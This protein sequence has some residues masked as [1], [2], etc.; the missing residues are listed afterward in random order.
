MSSWRGKLWLKA[1]ALAVAG[2]FAFSEV[3]WAA[4][5]DFILPS[6]VTNRNIPSAQQNQAP[7]KK[8]LLETFNEIYTNFSSVLFPFA[9]AEVIKEAVESDLISIFNRINRGGEEYSNTSDRITKSEEI[10]GLADTATVRQSDRIITKFSQKESGKVI[11]QTVSGKKAQELQPYQIMSA[12]FNEARKIESTV[13]QSTSDSFYYNL[14]DL[15]SRQ[16]VVETLQIPTDCLDRSVYLFRVAGKFNLAP[17]IV[18]IKDKKAN[19]GHALLAI[20]DSGTNKRVIIETT[21]KKADNGNGSGYLSSYL[22]KG[23]EVLTIARS[24]K[25]LTA[26]LNKEGRGISI[27]WGDGWGSAASSQASSGSYSTGSFTAGSD[28]GTGSTISSSGSSSWYS[29]SSFSDSSSFSYSTAV[30]PSLSST[31]DTSSLYGSFGSFISDYSIGSSFSLPSTGVFSFVYSTISSSFDYVYSNTATTSSV[32]SFNI[33]VTDNIPSFSFSAL[34]SGDTFSASYDT[35]SQTLSIPAQTIA[36]ISSVLGKDATQTEYEAA[37]YYLGV[38]TFRESQDSVF[39]ADADSDGLTKGAVSAHSAVLKQA[40]ESFAAGSIGSQEWSEGYTW[41]ETGR[42]LLEAETVTKS[43]ESMQLYSAYSVSLGDQYFLEAESAEKTGDYARASERYAE[44][45]KQFELA[46]NADQGVSLNNLVDASLITLIGET[47]SKIGETDKALELYSLALQHTSNYKP[48]QFLLEQLEKG[49][50]G[51]GQDNAVEPR[52]ACQSMSLCLIRSAFRETKLDITQDS[53]Q[54]ELIAVT[55]DSANIASGSV[56]EGRMQIQSLDDLAQENSGGISIVFAPGTDVTAQQQKVE[57]IDVQLGTAQEALT[58]AENTELTTEGKT[59]IVSVDFGMDSSIVDSQAD[60]GLVITGSNENVVISGVNAGGTLVIENNDDLVVSGLTAGMDI[61]LVDSKESAV[62]DIEALTG[63]IT[64]DTVTGSSIDTVTAEGDVRLSEV[65]GSTLSDLTAEA[66]DVSVSQVSDSTINSVSSLT[67]DI[68]IEEVVSSNIGDIEAGEDVRLTD[69]TGS[70][71][72]SLSAE[73]GSITVSQV[74][75]SVLNSIVSSAGDINIECITSSSISDIAAAEDISLTDISGSTVKG[76]TADNGSISINNAVDSALSNIKSVNGDIVFNDLSGS[77]IKSISAQEDMSFTVLTDTVADAISG[78]AALTINNSEAI[79]F[80]GISGQNGDLYLSGSSLDRTSGTPALINTVDLKGSISLSGI[81][82]VADPPLTGENYLPGGRQ[83]VLDSAQLSQQ[84]SSR[85]SISFEKAETFNDIEYVMLSKAPPQSIDIKAVA[86]LDDLSSDSTVSS[87]LSGVMDDSSILKSGTFTSL[88][89]YEVTGTESSAQSL[90]D[91]L[92]L[93]A[94]NGIQAAEDKLPV[95]SELTADAVSAMT[96]AEGALSYPLQTNPLGGVQGTVNTQGSGDS[97]ST[98]AASYALSILPV[99]SGILNNGNPQLSEYLTTTASGRG[100][101]EAATS[102]YLSSF[103]N[104]GSISYQGQNSISVSSSYLNN[105]LFSI[106]IDR[107]QGGVL[108]SYLE[109]IPPISNGLF[110]TTKDLS[111]SGSDK[112]PDLTTLEENSVALPDYV[113]AQG[114]SS[115]FVAWTNESAQTAWN[116]NTDQGRLHSG[117]YPEAGVSVNIYALPEGE[118][119]WGATYQGGEVYI[120]DN[121]YDTAVSDAQSAL[122]PEYNFKAAAE[123]IFVHDLNDYK[124]N[125][126]GSIIDWTHEQNQGAEAA[127]L[128]LKVDQLAQTAEGWADEDP[129]KQESLSAA[130]EYAA[131]F[132]VIAGEEISLDQLVYD[133]DNREFINTYKGFSERSI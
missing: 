31:W 37:F 118:A 97:S 133:T 43:T 82:A 29:V 85:L 69:I 100:P 122:Y 11:A 127:Y 70:T 33:V 99:L 87:L 14:A 15:K 112:V 25:E 102:D 123:A 52:Y 61:T 129:L 78:S 111:Y 49:N 64:I 79:E 2:I 126:D 17:E 12:F 104:S 1:I 80:Q 13:Y 92:S 130:A 20:N 90:K 91:L 101:P 34:A 74:T 131:K 60:R 40:G 95:N 75:A 116:W 84:D 72:N 59:K 24:L 10:C 120:T 117:A 6:V 115:D 22:N 121:T 113:S 23:C 58:L 16:A 26:F 132:N 119:D 7:V 128:V 73:A 35:D 66:G 98:A 93:T 63:S 28:S 65:N 83:L 56:S 4:R 114:F 18:I 62:S 41:L 21:A 96:A 45:A 108:S 54:V 110:S 3:T 19:I 88:K 76:I 36:N 9:H 53:Q 50:V 39:Q 42:Q 125:E 103:L 68:K 124:V 67:G 77:E 44:A 94:E 57:G 38:K 5:T 47:Y 89:P 8:S 105:N 30:I 27:A 81:A 107:G 55:S 32:P 71:V 51:I 86:A 48:A 109:G 106:T 46:F